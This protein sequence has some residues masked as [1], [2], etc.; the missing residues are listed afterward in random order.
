[1]TSPPTI[2]TK[3]QIIFKDCNFYH[4]IKIAIKCKHF[5]LVIKWDK[6]VFGIDSCYYSS[7]ITSGT[8]WYGDWL[9][10]V[11]AFIN[12]VNQF[13]RDSLIITGIGYPASTVNYIQNGDTI[14]QLNLSFGKEMPSTRINEEKFEN[15]IEMYPNPTDNLIQIS[16]K[17]NS[18]KIYQIKIFDM[19]GKLKY[20]QLTKN[21][22]D[23]KIDI[24][25]SNFSNGLYN[26]IISCDNVVYSNKLIINK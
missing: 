8:G 23:S 6:S 10:G 24:N 21:K 4:L 16:F 18:F 5:P 17:N 13:Y 1:M 14:I 7:F 2:H 11:M 22:N 20:N 19:L 25:T 12:P 15:A 9:D 26:I 3:K